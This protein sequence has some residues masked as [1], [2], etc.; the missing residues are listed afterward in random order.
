MA[1]FA[2]KVQDKLGR[3]L[4]KSRLVNKDFTLFSNDCWGTEVYKYFELPYNTPFVGLML[5]APC[6]VKLLQN[7]RYYLAQPLEFIEKSRYETVN[8]VQAERAEAFPMAT[9]AGD[10]EVQFLHYH[11]REEA[12]EKW[13]RRV[14]RINWDNVVVK[15]DGSKDYATP[16]LLERFEQLPYRKLLLLAAS[17]PLVPSAVV[18]PNYSINGM[19]Q[20]R[21]SLPVFD[22]AGWLNTG[23]ASVQNWHKLYHKAL[24]A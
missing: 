17:E 10:V 21:L 8:T 3:S 12:V 15:L 18:V 7:P 14:A 13:T 6:Y 20:F 4:Q 16:A 1:S 19:A 22:L 9:L 24:Y 2:R 11:S 5:M 23:T